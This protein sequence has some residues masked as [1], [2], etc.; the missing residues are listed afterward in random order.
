QISRIENVGTQGTAGTTP[1]L[2]NA[3]A[4][5]EFDTGEDEESKFITFVAETFRPQRDDSDWHKEEKPVPTPPEISA[6]TKDIVARVVADQSTASV[7]TTTVVEDDMTS[8]ATHPEDKAAKTQMIQQQMTSE[9]VS[10]PAASSPPTAYHDGSSAVAALGA[11]PERTT[12]GNPQQSPSTAEDSVTAVAKEFSTR[13]NFSNEETTKRWENVNASRRKG[14]IHSSTAVRVVAFSAMLPGKKKRRQVLE[15]L[16]E[17]L[18]L[19]PQ[20]WNESPLIGIV[21]LLALAPD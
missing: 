8:M 21:L 11:T 13:G 10:S 14:N 17:E 2:L 15:V 6:D 5:E 20:R 18:G 12:I 19:W 7:P 9:A 4:H 3:S 16:P 1:A